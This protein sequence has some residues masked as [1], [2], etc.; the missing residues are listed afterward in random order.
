MSMKDKFKNNKN[1]NEKQKKNKKKKAKRSVLDKV[2]I[3]FLAVALLLGL[4]G[5]SLLGYIIATTNGSG[6][7]AQMVNEEPTTFYAVDGS[8]MGEL[9]MESRQNISYQEIPES[10]VDAFLAI[11][12]SRFFKH[13]GFDL[14]RFIS[15]ALTNLKSGSFA[16][17]GST[18]TMQTIDNFYM[19]PTE[20]KIEKEGKNFNSLQKV[21]RKLKEI[22]MSMRLETQSTK[23]EIIEKYLNQ[24]N[25]GEARGIER[26]AQLFFGKSAKDLN[27]SESAYLAGCINAPNTYNPYNGYDAATKANYYKYATERRDETLAMMLQHGY[28]TETEH[29]L[30]KSTKLAFQVVGRS[31][32]ANDPYKNFITSAKEEAI[33]LT[34]KDPATTPMKIYTTMDKQAQEY[35]NKIANGEVVG[36][37]DNPEYQIAFTFL[38]NKT[39]G[40]MAVCP[41]RNDVEQTVYKARFEDVDRLPGSSIKPIIDYAY[42]LDNLGYCTSRVYNDKEMTIDGRKI[43]NSDGKFYGKV[44]MERA[45][46]QSLNMPAL[47]TIQSAV[48]RNGIDGMKKYLSDFGF[49]QKTVDDFNLLYGIGGTMSVSPNQMAAAFAALANGGVYN[50]PH[51][52]SRI[53][54]KDG[55]TPAIDVKTET[56]QVLSPQAAYMTSDLLY[57]A[58]NGKHKGWNLMGFLGFGA[59]PVYGKTGTSDWADD[60]LKYG[61][62]LLAMK[63]EWMINYTSEYTIATWS[64][65]D[66]GGP[67]NYITMEL[68]NAN[69]PGW[70]NKSMLDT[71]SKNPVLIANPGG[72]SS[73]GGGMIKSDALADAA[74]NNPMTEQN[75]TS[76]I[77]NLQKVFD[78]LKGV[79]G[80]GYESSSYAAF[81]AVL[82]EA[83]KMIEHDNYTEAQYNDMAAR[84]QAAYDALV[85][86]ADKS[87]LTAAINQAAG[88][89]PNVYTSESYNNLKAVV[90]GAKAVL[91]KNNVTQQEID[92]QIALINNAIAGL[93]KNIDRSGLQAAISNAYTKLATLDS[94]SQ[95]YKSLQ[96]AINAASSIYNSASATQAQLDAQTAS[97]NTILSAL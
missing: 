46:A 84:L 32:S 47:Q 88:L 81:K 10:T 96:D 31:S 63:D 48:E 43:Q 59:Y 60:G 70:I 34:G 66:T 28:I 97:L 1:P 4:S 56:R 95:N 16:Q 68:L 38:D 23:N 29:D 44:S 53:E 52:I 30:A 54:F 33:A 83:S 93:V 13:N 77:D 6:L 89:N 20:V 40:I 64:G 75:V 57:K 67:N 41:G 17:G 94:A 80:D 69:I 71:L 18:L 61:I 19:K 91:N 14:P 11:E 62:P 15:S 58:V 8:D 36:L 12:D 86:I 42:A 76:A 73:Y 55:K 79:A 7:L 82:E 72:I 27:L 50:K 49:D 21:E 26:G 22:Y 25:F 24:I 39:G 5:L 85:P 51:M 9:G 65:F 78:A 37:S 92:A 35:A 87:G 3:V 45:I 90:D 74:K 2:V